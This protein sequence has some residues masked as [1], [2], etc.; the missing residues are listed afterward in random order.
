MLALE[1]VVR[2]SFIGGRP[3]R[4]LEPAAQLRDGAV[5]VA[6]LGFE[7][8]ELLG[9][10]RV[11]LLLKVVGVASG[12][13]DCLAQLRGFRRVVALSALACSEELL[14]LANHLG[15][16]SCDHGLQLVDLALALCV[17]SLTCGGGPS[18]AAS[19][20]SRRARTSRF[21][22]SSSTSASSAI[23]DPPATSMAHD[24]PPSAV[25]RSTVAAH[26]DGSTTGRHSTVPR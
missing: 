24:A 3:G 21:T 11:M 20:A 10:G 1:I 15:A 8:L 19:S 7:L 5:Q 2:S 12:G 22:A 16:Q 25:A 9:E 14:A 13:D 23:H 26:G 17:G 18:Q 6:S 4:D